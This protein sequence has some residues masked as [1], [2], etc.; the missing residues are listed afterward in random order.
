MNWGWVGTAPPGFLLSLS[1]DQGCHQSWCARVD[2][3]SSGKTISNFSLVETLDSDYTL[4]S[5]YP[6]EVSVTGKEWAELFKFPAL[7][8][9]SEARLPIYNQIQTHKINKLESQ[10]LNSLRLSMAGCWFFPAIFESKDM[11]KVLLVAQRRPDVC[12]QK[13]Q[14]SI[15]NLPLKQIQVGALSEFGEITVNAYGSNQF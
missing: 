5:P 8:S 4:C 1:L 9:H 11:Q 13:G 14:V 7:L 6:Q 3:G 15:F 2:W 10:D 12:T